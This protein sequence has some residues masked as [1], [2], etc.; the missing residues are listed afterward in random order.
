MNLQEFRI[1]IDQKIK[2]LILLQE[3][4]QEEKIPPP[5]ETKIEGNNT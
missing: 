1:K 2:D 5:Q 4:S 3:Q